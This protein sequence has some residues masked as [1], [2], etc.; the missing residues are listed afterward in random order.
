VTTRFSSLRARLVGTVFLALA[1]AWALTFFVAMHAGQR[2]DL[3][4]LL[5]SSAIGLLALAVAWF[6]GERF[7]LRQ[8]RI[9]YESI[10][11]LSEGDF[12]S[13][14]GL[15][16]EGGEL[17][18]LARTFDALAESLEQRV[19]EREL[20]EQVLLARSLQQTVVSAL[21]QFALV[22]DDFGALLNQAA[23]LV[24][25]TL[26]VQYCGILELRPKRKDLLLRAGIGWRRGWVGHTSFPVDA[27]SQNGFTL[28]AG[29]PVVVEDLRNE[30]RFRGGALLRDHGVVSG[31]TVAIRGQ[32]RP[33]GVLG[34]H[35]TSPRKFTEDEVQFLLAVATVL[36]LAVARKLGEAQLEKLAAFVQ[37]S[38]NPVM[39]LAGDGSPTYFNEAAVKLATSAG[40]VNPAGILPPDISSIAQLCLATGESRVDVETRIAGRVLAWS[41]HPVKRS[42]VVHAYVEDITDRLSLEAQLRQSQKLDSIGQLAAGV[43]HDF[44]NMLTIIQGHGGML[45]SKAA[46]DPELME[47]AQA[48]CFAAERA[49]NLTRQL[50]MF[51]R[52]NVMQ[53]RALDLRDVVAQMGKMLQ[54][55]LGETITL[56]FQSPPRLP[57]VQG[58]IGMI[59]QVIMNLAVNARDAMPNGGALEIATMAAAIDEAY[60]HSHPE[61]RPGSFVCLRVSDSGCG[62]DP[63]NMA[64]IFEPF[65]TTK[66]VGKGTGLGLATVYG[67]VKQHGGWVDVASEVGRGTCFDV[68]FPTSGEPIEASSSVAASAAEVRGG[69]E[70]ILVVEDEPVLRDLAHVI[71]EERGYNILEASSGRDALTVWERHK[72]SIDLVLTDMVMPEGISGLDLA[73]RLLGAKPDLKLVFASGYSMDD[74]DPAL[75]RDRQAIF[76]QKPYTALTLAKAVRDCLD[77]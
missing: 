65:F 33:F 18:E 71:L 45:F 50:L 30:K 15:S 66:E 40:Q 1:P 72:E 74:L 57:C 4:W 19:K 27:R 8:V 76:L 43:A 64:R 56:Q 28:A 20:G 10:R 77:N 75:V 47:S 42:Q 37:L 55:L 63:Y 73:N 58:D 5:L 34:A 35:T 2:R 16:K 6:G 21:G 44:N 67:I 59:E 48:I 7:L 68:F 17:G 53:P 11:R 41:F 32:G 9:L 49:A 31:L 25:Q 46:Q 23:I 29:E 70:T 36:A 3:P 60:A 52:K 38:P 12:A 54:R 14:T 62:I 39:E 69:Q 61:A 51:S 22:S 26:E 24:A 13:R